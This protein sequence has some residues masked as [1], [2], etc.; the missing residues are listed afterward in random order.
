M[1][2]GQNRKLYDMIHEAL[3]KH[4]ITGACLYLVFQA[5]QGIQGLQPHQ[6]WCKVARGLVAVTHWLTIILNACTCP[7]RIEAYPVYK[8]I[9]KLKVVPTLIRRKTNVTLNLPKQASF[10]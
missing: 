3:S 9:Y 5:H 6:V 7:E 8:D 4:N 1:E 10:C 2:G